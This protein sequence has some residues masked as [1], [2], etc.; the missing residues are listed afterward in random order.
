MRSQC[1]TFHWL[2]VNRVRLKCA[3][4]IQGILMGCFLFSFLSNF[5]R[6]LIWL[7]LDRTNGRASK[8]TSRTMAV[9]CA[10]GGGFSSDIECTLLYV[11]ILLALF[12][13]L[14][15]VR[16]L[17]RSHSPCRAEW[18]CWVC[19]CLKIKWNDDLMLFKVT[20]FKRIKCTTM[21]ASRWLSSVQNQSSSKMTTTTTTTTSA[22][23][24]AT[25]LPQNIIAIKC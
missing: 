5:L 14:S 2:L 18:C 4:I 25:A 3:Q 16:T 20:H 10:L 13:S 9:Y 21:K 15:L 22:A 19:A 24:A 11:R 1:V 8:G 12:L 23:I 7:W 17:Y 6:W